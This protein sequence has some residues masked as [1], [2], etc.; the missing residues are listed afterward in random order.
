MS[1][2]VLE[3]FRSGLDVRRPGLVAPAGTLTK[4]VNAH[5]TAGGDIEKRYAFK[6]IA[7]AEAGSIGLAVLGSTL[8]VF[9]DG[10]AKTHGHVPEEVSEFRALE[11]QFLSVQTIY[12]PMPAGKTAVR[13]VDWDLFNGQIYSVIQGDDDDFYHFY[14]SNYVS[15]INSLYAPAPYS[16]RTF[17]SKIYGL[18]ADR[19]VF[20]AIDNPL[21]WDPDDKTGGALGQGFIY[22]QNSGGNS[23][24]LSGL[25]IYYDQLAVASRYSTQIW[26]IDADPNNNNLRQTLRG[27][28]TVA[29]PTM[30]QFGS[31]DVL[32]LHD[33]GIR[34]LRA[35]DSSNAAAVSDIGSPIDPIIQDLIKSRP[36]NPYIT[37]AFSLI[38]ANT[39][40]FWMCFKDRIFVLSFFP[41]P[42]VTAWSEYVPE[43]PIE[44]G[45]V[46][47]GQVIFRSGNNIYAYGGTDGKTY[48]NCEVIVEI[49]PLSVS[50][51]ATLK[52]FTAID[53]AAWG[54]WTVETGFDPNIPQARDAVC[55]V[56][57]P[58][59][60]SL[61]SI[62]LQ[63]TS[64]H[65]AMKLRNQAHGPATL[66]AIA[67]HYVTNGK[68]D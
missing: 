66:S 39:G 57:A 23:D 33:S 21:V 11:T 48:D 26:E 29:P 46:A 55:A 44:Y 28:G 41:G 37:R 31:G 22:T 36:N 16:I 52:A 2:F 53:L 68:A 51:P 15:Q 14:G 62:A 20:C 7:T 24:V 9:K 67:V 3:D 50:K 42:K 12:I 54:D 56:S 1:Y 65:I 60:G 61:G 35:K 17:K 40:R 45:V 30:L 64:T 38:E 25:E 43:F 8:F 27:A 32:Y 4:L 49:P 18:T 59:F 58:T 5:L 47:E 19:L 34:S 10:V 6:K 13:L 63:G